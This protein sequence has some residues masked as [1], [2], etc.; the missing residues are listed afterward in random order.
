MWIVELALRRPYTFVVVSM[1]IALLGVLSITRMAT[2]IFP[3]I[4]LPVVS[5]IWQYTGLSPEDVESRMVLISERAMTT[6]TSEIEHL[7]SNSVNGYGV[8]K[9]YLRQ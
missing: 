7:E 9:L 4:N 5:V 3:V 1:L 2:D 8:I 6:V